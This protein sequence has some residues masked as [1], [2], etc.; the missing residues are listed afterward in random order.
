MRTPLFNAWDIVVNIILEWT[1]FL[2]QVDRDIKLTLKTGDI[3]QRKIKKETKIIFSGVSE[4]SKPFL[5]LPAA[6]QKLR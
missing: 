5:A 6:V 3:I 4:V 2:P 1:S